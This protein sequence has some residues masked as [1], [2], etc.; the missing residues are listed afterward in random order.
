VD[1]GTARTLAALNAPGGIAGLA[2][3][4]ND[5]AAARKVAQQFG[6]MLMQNLMRQSDGSALPMAGGTGGDIVNTMFSTTMGQAAMAHD[7]T[8][9]TDMLLRSLQQKQRQADGGS[10]EPNSAPTAASRPTSFPL[11]G[12][13]QG[14]G[15]RPLATALAASLPG[16]GAPISTLLAA[17]PN[18][19]TK[20]TA[21]FGLHGQPLLS[22]G[23]TTFPSGS[24]PASGSVSSEQIAAF[25]QKLAPLLEKAG[26][27]LGVSPKI[28]LAQTAIE[29]GW[30]RSVVGNNLFGIKAGSSWPGPQVTAATH[31]Y[32]NGQYV[33]IQDSFRAYPSAEASVQDFV[34]L[35]SNSNRYRAA[36]GSGGDVAAYAQGLLSGG[37]ATDI[38]YAHK[39]KTVAASAAVNAAFPGP[40]AP[41]TPVVPVPP[42][43]P[44]PLLPADFAVARP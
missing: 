6:A 5:P 10:A 32:E 42:G 24:G 12:Y 44:T 8:G 19:N 37:W 21:A 20:M 31:E 16:V 18:M 33:A 15:L 25:T 14:N 7:R 22:N 4:A 9:L 26:Q 23:T 17:M 28:L 2:K 3:H 34:S 30:G 43:Q 1:I 41:T 40:A 39:L 38:D 29:T 11:A 35:V 36:L 13:W 27:Q